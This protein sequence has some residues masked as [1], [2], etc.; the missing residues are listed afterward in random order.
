[1]IIYNDFGKKAL[2]EVLF[3]CYLIICFI[4]FERLPINS[5]RNQIC[6]SLSFYIKIYYVEVPLMNKEE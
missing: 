1:M 6:E 5:W 3:D 4:W 2:K